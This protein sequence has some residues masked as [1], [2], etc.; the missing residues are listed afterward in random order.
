[1]IAAHAQEHGGILRISLQRALPCAITGLALITSPG[2]ARQQPVGSA[3]LARDADLR[4]IGVE[5][6]QGFQDRVL[7]DHGRLSGAPGS[8]VQDSSAFL[9]GKPAVV[10]VYVGLAQ[11]SAAAAGAVPATGHLIVYAAGDSLVLEPLVSTECQRA[12]GILDACADTIEVWPSFG[13]Q[14]L[15]T[16]SDYDLDLIDARSAWSGSLNFVIPAAATAT[17]TGS[18]TLRAVVSPSAS[19]GFRETV[20]GDN[21]FLVAIDSVESPRRLQ[22]RLVRV[23]TPDAPPPDRL[24]ADSVLQ[25]MLRLTPYSQVDVVSDTTYAYDGEYHTIRVK[26]LFFTISRRVLSHCQTLWLRL[27]QSAGV[28]ANRP[29]LA[30]APAN[31]RLLSTDGTPCSNLGAWLPATPLTSNRSGGVA[32]ARMPAYAGDSQLDLDRVLSVTHELYHAAFDR[33]HVSNDHGEAIGCDIPSLIGTISR[34]RIDG[35][36]WKPT[37]YPH[38]VIGAWPDGNTNSG[39]AGDRGGMGIDIVQTANGWSLTLYD[40][41]PGGRL[42]R[43]SP[44]TTLVQR[45]NINRWEY[46]CQLPDNVRAHDLMSYGPLRWTSRAQFFHARHGTTGTP[47]PTGR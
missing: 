37:P 28:D 32:L 42:D 24:L 14:G 9:A 6:N 16:R 17:V 27:F 20:P 34:G 11:T 29:L 19:R 13:R 38:G 25:A 1:M 36:C 5:I 35:D 39:I 3:V 47:V 31:A 18:L 23:G 22:V 7:T 46:A 30:L 43:N 12:P 33:R 44:I 2:R 4:V 15:P 40:A 21:E 10:R 45:M 41:C 8:A 26:F